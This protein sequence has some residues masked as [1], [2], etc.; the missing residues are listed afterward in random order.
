MRRVAAFVV[1]FLTGWAYAQSDPASSPAS[2]VP[3]SPVLSY[4]GQHVGLW[5]CVVGCILAFGLGFIGGRQR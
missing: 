3:L 4:D 5:V 2:S 1:A